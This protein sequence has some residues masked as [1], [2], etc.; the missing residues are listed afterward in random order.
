[1]TIWIIIVPRSRASILAAVCDETMPFAILEIVI[2][3]LIDYMS[4]AC[5]TM[6]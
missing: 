1:M 4:G 6:Y 3:L 2:L 5:K